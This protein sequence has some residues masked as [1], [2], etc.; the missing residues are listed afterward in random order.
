ME[1]KG[2]ENKDWD[3]CN[4]RIT[5]LN[6]QGKGVTTTSTITGVC[7]KFHLLCHYPHILMW[8]VGRTVA[9]CEQ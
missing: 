3:F 8:W 1:N 4:H 6:E 7:T 5:I 9:T 2:W